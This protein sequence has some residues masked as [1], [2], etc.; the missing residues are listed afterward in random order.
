MAEP[1]TMRVFSRSVGGEG[2]DQLLR[3]LWELRGGERLS[4]TV[5]LDSS[6]RKQS[7]AVA[8]V[9]RGGWVEV[10]SLDY[11]ER[12]FPAKLGRQ[13]LSAM[14]EIE[15]VLIE[16]AVWALGLGLGD[17]GALRLLHDEVEATKEEECEGVPLGYSSAADMLAE[18]LRCDH[19]ISYFGETSP[20][21]LVTR[22][23]ALKFLRALSL[24]SDKVDGKR[25]GQI[26]MKTVGL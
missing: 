26:G 9:W 14:T 19:P 6:Y 1:V 12:E 21:A 23:C 3:S 25:S 22:S 20:L 2:Q 11:R 24:N 17:L 10:S 4:V 8:K 15:H 16:R 18:L 5:R 13:D 7:H